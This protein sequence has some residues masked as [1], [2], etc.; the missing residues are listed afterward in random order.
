M[1]S[2]WYFLPFYWNFLLHWVSATK[3]SLVGR[4]N[5]LDNTSFVFNKYYLYRT[6]SVRPTNFNKMAK[7]PKRRHWNSPWLTYLLYFSETF[8]VL[9]Y[10]FLRTFPVNSQEFFSYFLDSFNILSW[11]ITST[12]PV[13]FPV[14]YQDQD[15]PL[16][17]YIVL[18]L[19][20]NFFLADPGKVR[21]C[22]T[23]TSV[24]NWL[25][26]SV[27]VCEKIFTAPPRPNGCIYMVL[28]VRK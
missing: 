23:N 11:Y 15:I 14:F 9:S 1:S 3:E 4:K 13:F 8:Q 22:S 28:S 27:M 20:W 7:M 25:I 24:I 6:D 5:N 2:F 10:H 16:L 26:N 18:L 21:G 19:S 17:L 12:L